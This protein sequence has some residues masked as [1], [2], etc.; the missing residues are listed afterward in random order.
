MDNIIAKKFNF[1]LDT[2]LVKALR[3]KSFICYNTDDI[4]LLI[5]VIE[6][7]AEKILDNSMVEV[8][9]SYPNGEVATPIKQTME[10]GGIEIIPDNTITIITAK[11][12]L[13]PT[14]Y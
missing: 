1:Q 7:G 4:E 3:D 13:F 10:E 12:C 8:I 5:D 2:K 14:E 9:Y 6:N 11:G